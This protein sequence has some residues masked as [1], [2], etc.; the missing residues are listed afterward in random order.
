MTS[1]GAETRPAGETA[2]GTTVSVDC[3]E[4]MV[5]VSVVV[6][7]SVTVETAGRSE[8]TVGGNAVTRTWL[9]ADEPLKLAVIC[10]SPGDSAE[11]A[12]C[13]LSCPAGTLTNAGTAAMAEALLETATV[14]SPACAAEMVTVSVPLEPCVRETVA[15]ASWVMLG[16]DG[17]TFTAA[18]AEPP[19]ALAE[20][21]VLPSAMPVTGISTV[22]W[23]ATNATVAGTVAT[24]VFALETDNVPAWVGD[25]ESV[26]VSAP[27]APAVMD[28]GFGASEVGT[29]RIRV[30]RIVSVT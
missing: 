4:E 2:S 5:S 17:V 10:A 8:T 22:F 27:A 21:V 7:P 19:F 16:G 1:A 11:T 14:V 18:L 6:A 28:R 23:P 20:T 25:G 26:A 12:I 9:D 15:G 29:G 30:P 24:A 13:A 3:A